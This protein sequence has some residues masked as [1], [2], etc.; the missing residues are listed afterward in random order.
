MAE[1]RLSFARVTIRLQKRQ[2]QPRRR[3]PCFRDR[4]RYRAGQQC[5]LRTYA[6][7]FEIM[8]QPFQIDD[9]ARVSYLP[10]MQLVVTDGKFSQKV[11]E[12]TIRSSL[13]TMTSFGC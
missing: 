8:R 5:D 9:M 2:G 13:L 4:R 6:G 10:Q 12:Y 1:L 11:K 7:H 3:C